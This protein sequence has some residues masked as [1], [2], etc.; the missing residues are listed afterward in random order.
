MKIL[1]TDKYMQKTVI[2]SRE[3]GN[4]YVVRH[5]HLRQKILD[6]HRFLHCWLLRKYSKASIEIITYLILFLLRYMNSRCDFQKNL[7][8]ISEGEIGYWKDLQTR[9]SNYNHLL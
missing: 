1:H 3:E 8:L 4:S 2:K 9:Y 6:H 7:K 5:G